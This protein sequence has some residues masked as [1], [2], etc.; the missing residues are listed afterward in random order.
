V[1]PKI[2]H[3]VFDGVVEHLFRRFRKKRTFERSTQC[4]NLIH[5]GAAFMDYGTWHL[6][7]YACDV[8]WDP[9]C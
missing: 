3:F 7:K 4:A 5:L 8:S 9:G 1:P 6:L 2:C